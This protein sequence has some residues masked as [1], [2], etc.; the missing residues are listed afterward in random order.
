VPVAHLLARRLVVPRL[1]TLPR[2]WRIVWPA[3]AALVGGYLVVAIPAEVRPWVPHRLEIEATGDRGPSARGSVVTVES[4]MHDSASRVPW[5]ALEPVGRWE[6]AEGVARSARPQPATLRWAG[7]ARGP[8]WVRFVAHPAAGIVE[9]TWDGHRKRI[10]LWAPRR[11]ARLV[12]LPSFWRSAGTASRGHAMLL[13]V[14]SAIALAALLLASGVWLATRPGAIGRAA[15]GRASALVYAAPCVAVWTA[16]LLALWPGLLSSDSEEQWAQVV[17]GR[18]NNFHPAAHSLAMWLVTRLWL[19]PAAVVAAQIVGMALVVG[20]FVREL[21]SWRVPAWARAAVVIALAASPVNGIMVATLWKDVGYTIACLLVTV[22][23]LRIVRTRGAAGRSPAA[24]VM[25]WLGLLCMALFRH[26]GALVAAGLALGLPLVWAGAVRR[27]LALAGVAAFAAYAVVVWPVFRALGVTPSRPALVLARHV[28]QLA[29]MVH[30]G[31]PL[32]PE[33]AALVAVLDPADS[34]H[35]LYSCY[36]LDALFSEGGT[37][38]AAVDHHQGEVLDAWRALAPRHV[39]LLVADQVGCAASLVWRVRPAAD[40]RLYTTAIPPG[41]AALQSRWPRLL[42]ALRRV[43]A[44]TED[45]ARVWWTWR[46]ALYLY[47]LVACAV[48][49]AARGRDARLLLVAAPAVL[50]SLVWVALISSQD[51]RYQYPVYATALMVP[52]LTVAPGRRAR[53]GAVE[54][55]ADAALNGTL[56]PTIDRAI[57]RSIGTDL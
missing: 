20:L 53:P 57:P 4:I 13:A 49:A 7:S 21:A 16:Y 45:P 8:M 51:T 48:V 15:V 55:P 26:N 56:A 36:F 35:R 6:I 46:P 32:E 33:Q 30:A 3:L 18:F 38:M 10:D 47:L 50:N 25:L 22:V 39:G 28:Q 34:W 17:S 12:R 41:D 52:A 5:S 43:V 23:L 40:A 24:L 11:A 54:Q 37:D 2:A 19:S 14:A 44:W 31:A 42:R 1:A 9:L 29:A 27:R